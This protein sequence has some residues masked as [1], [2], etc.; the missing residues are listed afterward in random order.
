MQ[1]ECKEMATIIFLIGIYLLTL[2]Q[3]IFAAVH[4]KHVLYPNFRLVDEK[5][6]Y[7][8]RVWNTW[9]GK[10]CYYLFLIFHICF[11]A[12]FLFI[13]IRSFFVL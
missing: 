1:S 13:F 6:I 8:T 9:Y 7:G 10:L 11:I 12:G 5:M 2:Y 3:V 4:G